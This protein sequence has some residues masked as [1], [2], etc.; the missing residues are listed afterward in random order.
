M[1]GQAGLN[2]M[3]LSTCHCKHI[4]VCLKCKFQ[5]QGLS[6]QML[7]GFV[8]NFDKYFMF[9]IILYL[10]SLTKAMYESLLFCSLTNKNI[11]TLLRFCQSARKKKKCFSEICRYKQGNIVLQG[12]W[13]DG[14]ISNECR[15]LF[16]YCTDFQF[17]SDNNPWWNK[18]GEKRMEEKDPGAQCE[19]IQI[20]KWCLSLLPTFKVL[21]LVRIPMEM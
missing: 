4:Q 3:T 18:T 15:S 17:I 7:N 14:S 1:C 12:I 9:L 10:F 11:I 8:N 21:D 16:L 5:M 19:R 20:R 6:S 2:R 13:S